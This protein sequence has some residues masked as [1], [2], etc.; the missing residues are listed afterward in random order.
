MDGEGVR[1]GRVEV[2]VNR[3]WGT[4]CD[5]LFTQDDAD[6]VCAQLPG[7]KR[8]GI[9]KNRNAFFNFFVL[10]RS[11]KESFTHTQRR[12]FSTAPIVGQTLHT[13]V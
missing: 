8:E 13:L 11:G 5:S 4:V 9:Y 1:R 6:V 3:A 10:L 2:C 12:Y 7:F